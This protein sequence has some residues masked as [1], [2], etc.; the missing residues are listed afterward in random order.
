MTD[1]RAVR[2]L[3]DVLAVKEEAPGLARVVTWSDEY[4]VDMRDGGCACPDKEYNE[5]IMCKHEYAALVADIETPDPFIREIDAAALA[6]GGG[7]C[8]ECA[9]LPDGWPCAECYITGDAKITEEPYA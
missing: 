1:A 4:Y 9:A 5:P 8:E 7:E 2:A 6:D 3:T